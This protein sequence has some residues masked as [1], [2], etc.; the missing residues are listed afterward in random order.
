MKKDFIKKEEID[1]AIKKAEKEYISFSKKE[2]KEKREMLF[3]KQ[4][5][6]GYSGQ[7][8]FTSVFLEVLF[9][10][11]KMSYKAFDYWLS[12]IVKKMEGKYTFANKEAFTREKLE[13]DSNVFKKL[14][15]K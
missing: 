2:K 5:E 15:Y 10:E 13:F 8:N 14:L 9:L 6:W 1:I 4:K 11:T 3:K 7:Y 12:Y